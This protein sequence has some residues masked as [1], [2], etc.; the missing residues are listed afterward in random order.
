MDEHN[1][2]DMAFRK[3]GIFILYLILA[4]V[5]LIILSFFEQS[6]WGILWGVINGFVVFPCLFLYLIYGDQE[7]EAQ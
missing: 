6:G 1:D 4:I 5:V 3:L 2:L 7:S